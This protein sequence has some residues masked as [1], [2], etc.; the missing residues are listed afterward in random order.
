MLSSS[1]FT[2]IEN[3]S[4]PVFRPANSHV[5]SEK[6]GGHIVIHRQEKEVILELANHRCIRASHRHNTEQ[7]GAREPLWIRGLSELM[8]GTTVDSVA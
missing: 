3:D 1:P 4:V 2:R 5:T 6:G 8:I 7:T